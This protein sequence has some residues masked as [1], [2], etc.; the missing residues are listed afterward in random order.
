M[1]S[2]KANNSKKAQSARFIEAAREAGA[3]E[4]EDEAVFDENLKRVATPK[5]SNPHRRSHP[6]AFNDRSFEVRAV[7]DERGWR[8]RV[9]ENGEPATATV[10]TVSWETTIDA[11]MT[12]NVDVAD[13]LMETAQIS[14][15][16]GW[17]RLLK[18]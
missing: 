17:D 9:F 3:S 4:D 6:F 7:A 16:R 5:P 15:E 10:Y 14:L 18:P 11:S 8:V 12:L 2:R 1:P 13:H